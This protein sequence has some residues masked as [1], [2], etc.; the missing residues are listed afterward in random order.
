MIARAKQ[1]QEH[2]PRTSL[3]LPPHDL[4]SEQCLLGCIMLL[5]EIVDTMPGEV[6]PTDMYGPDNRDALDCAYRIRASGRMPDAAELYEVLASSMGKE[7]A[8]ELCRDAMAQVP[9]GG[10]WRPYARAIRAAAIRRA[11]IN[12]GSELIESGHDESAD[13]ED[14][15]ADGERTLR[16]ILEGRAGNVATPVRDIAPDIVD[17]MTTPQARGLPTGFYHLDLVLGGGMRPGQLAILAARPSVG[18]SALATNIAGNVARSGVGVLFL[19]LEMAST[20]LMLRM[21]SRE[22]RMTADEITSGKLEEYQIDAAMRGVETVKQWPLWIDE[23]AGRTMTQIGALAR[24]HC[25]RDRVGLIIVDYL[26]LIQ[27]EDRKANRQEQVASISR[28]LKLLAKN[29]RV[30]I[31]A[32]AQLNRGI[33]SRDDKTPRMADLRESGAIEQ[34]A[35]IIAFLDRPRLYDTDAPVDAANVYIAKNRNGAP[36]K[37]EMKWDARTTTF[38]DS[39]SDYTA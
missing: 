14:A 15:I 28:E 37:V 31:I 1:D 19:T 9:H 10:N 6:L 3:R 20:E 12:A 21:I 22:A 39:I 16:A 13:V 25:G 30:P 2:E 7:R 5:P 23:R 35:D 36:G 38:S 8:E 11:L 4:I 24:L 33:E 29:L 27:P 34:D 17:Q 26:Q 18:K 32:L